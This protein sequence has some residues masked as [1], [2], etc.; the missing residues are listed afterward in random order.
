MIKCFHYD[1]NSLKNFLKPDGKTFNI[2]ADIEIT[3]LNFGPYDNGHVVLGFNTGA[4]LILN[5]FDLSSM[6]RLQVFNPE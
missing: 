3:A 4:I 6:F 1:N 5:S 2:N